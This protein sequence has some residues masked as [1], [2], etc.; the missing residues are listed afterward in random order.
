MV[1]D[2][3]RYTKTHEWVKI[4]DNIAI[5]GVSDHAQEAL[6][7]ITYVEFPETGKVLEAS[8]EC[9]VV[10][11]VKAASDIY[12]PV[13]G[14]VT[15]INNAVADAPEIVNQ[16]PYGDGWLVKLSSPKPFSLKGL[17]KAGEYEAWLKEEK[18]K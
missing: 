7:D 15:E 13:S 6:G 9:G 8:E 2:D 17:M 16:D 5:I 3:R 1:P 10:E 14:R 11:S 4:E 18:A 12:A